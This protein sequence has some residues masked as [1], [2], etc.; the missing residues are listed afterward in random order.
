M[1]QNKGLGR[2]LA[3]L[4]GMNELDVKPVQTEIKQ[5]SVS[6]PTTAKNEG[7]QAIISD[8]GKKMMNLVDEKASKLA[9]PEH[10]QLDPSARIIA[11]QISIK[12]IDPNYEQPRKHFDE[13]A[14]NDLA[15]SIKIHGV[16]QPIVVVRMG[17]RFMIIAG[18]RRFRAAK[19]AGLNTIPAIIKNYSPQQ[20]RE[21]SL[22]E[23]LQ[24]EDLNPIE[25]AR[26]IKQLMEEFNMTQETAADRIGKSRSAIANTLR[27]LTLDSRVISLIEDGTLV[28][29]LGTY[30]PLFD[31]AMS[32]VV[33]VKARGA[34]VLALA[35]ESHRGEMA[36][37]V[38]NVIT[39]PDTAQMLL[40]SLGVVPLQLLAYY[41]ALQRGCD[42]DKPRNLAKSVTVE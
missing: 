33:E 29:A 41:I 22:I 2:G 39:I 31:K 13:A 32:N 37:T 34:D 18:E 38:E 27:L 8:K 9:A 6:A 25:A 19:M 5:E 24:R 42:I 10:V 23:N 35:T 1:A 17:M 4:L 28:I 21:I 20:I 15:E 40:P 14:L 7:A 16:I 3:S 36:K 12:D 11:I 30:A 26:A